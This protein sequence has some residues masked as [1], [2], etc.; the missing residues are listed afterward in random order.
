MGCEYRTNCFLAANGFS[1]RLRVSEMC[2]PLPWRSQGTKLFLPGPVS[3]DAFAQLT[4][5]ESLRDIEACLQSIGS[6]LYHMGSEASGTIHSG[7][8]KRS[9]LLA[10]LRRLCASLDRHRAPA[11]CERSD[12]TATPRSLQPI[13]SMRSGDDGV[14]FGEPSCQPRVPQQHP[15]EHSQSRSCAREPFPGCAPLGRSDGVVGRT[16][17]VGSNLQ[18]ES[19]IGGRLKALLYIF[20]QATRLRDTRRGCRVQGTCVGLFMRNNE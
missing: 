16:A 20:L 2:K 8:R 13:W 19:E 7:R 5:R 12:P 3:L 17:G 11:V 15:H 1:A 14:F 4:Y 6:K 10:E 18:C 9:T